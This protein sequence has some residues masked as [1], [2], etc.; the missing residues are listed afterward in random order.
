M[1]LKEYKRKGKEE[2]RVGLGDFQ[3]CD[4]KLPCELLPKS[5]CELLLH[6]PPVYGIDGPGEAP[7]TLVAHTGVEDGPY[8]ES[9]TLSTPVADRTHGRRERRVLRGRVSC[10]SVVPLVGISLVGPPVSPVCPP[11]HTSRTSL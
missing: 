4:D 9:P 7:R 3:R 1:C 2:E 5:S 6:P 8:V 10:R 11:C